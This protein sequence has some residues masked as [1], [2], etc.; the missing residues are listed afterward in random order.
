MGR[1]RIKEL[2]RIFDNIFTAL[3]ND[4]FEKLEI[5]F[6]EIKEFSLE[7]IEK[8]DIPDIMSKIEAVKDMIDQKQKGIISKISKK[9]NVK[10][11][12]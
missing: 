9:E 1:D 6:K 12:K 2:D 8:S 3:Q 10:H 4:D 11:Y 7:G 5:H